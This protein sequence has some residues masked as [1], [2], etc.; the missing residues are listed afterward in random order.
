MSPEDISEN[1]G[2]SHIVK[3]DLRVP[4]ENGYSRTHQGELEG[5]LCNDSVSKWSDMS[6]HR[7]L[8]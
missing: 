6:T 2:E 4:T 8:M 7:L 5:S 3:I 1:F